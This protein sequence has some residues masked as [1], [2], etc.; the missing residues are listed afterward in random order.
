MPLHAQ[1]ELQHPDVSLA[2]TKPGA[3]A[4]Q[5]RTEPASDAVHPSCRGRGALTE[6][7]SRPPAGW[8]EGWPEAPTAPG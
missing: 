7:P 1:V 6:S 3:V 4:V 2:R 5:G 8:K